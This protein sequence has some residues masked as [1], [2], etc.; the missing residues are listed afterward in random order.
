MTETPVFLTHRGGIFFPAHQAQLRRECEG[1]AGGTTCGW[2]EAKISVHHEKVIT[3]LLTQISNNVRDVY[4][5]CWPLVAADVKL[6]IPPVTRA[7]AAPWSQ[8]HPAVPGP[9]SPCHTTLQWWPASDA[10]AAAWRQEPVR[11][12]ERSPRLHHA[13]VWAGRC[14]WTGTKYRSTMKKKT[15]LQFRPRCRGRFETKLELFTL[16]AHR[17]KRLT[18]DG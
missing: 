14:G 11:P 2:N 16:F 5:R 17:W 15:R 4:F 13:R 8:E 7:P 6:L 10:A 12:E 1:G 18:A 3:S 9:L